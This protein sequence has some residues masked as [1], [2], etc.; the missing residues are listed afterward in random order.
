MG[1]SWSMQNDEANFT[2]FDILGLKNRWEETGASID[3]QAD[4][5]IRNE[6]VKDFKVIW[7]VETSNL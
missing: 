6:L 5:I 3:V 7:L 2:V 1:N 4:F